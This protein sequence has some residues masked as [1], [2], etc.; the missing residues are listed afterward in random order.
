MTTENM[1]RTIYNICVI[2]SGLMMMG[3]LSGCSLE[4]QVYTQVDKGNYVK[5]AAQAVESARAAKLV[6]AVVA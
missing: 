2:L 6:I 1:K 4:E 3:A 5:N